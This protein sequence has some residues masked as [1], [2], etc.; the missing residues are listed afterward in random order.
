M[1]KN[2]SGVWGKIDYPKI[3]HFIPLHT[4]I[5]HQPP[6]HSKVIHKITYL[7]HQKTALYKRQERCYFRAKH[8][9]KNNHLRAK[10][11]SGY[12]F[13][14]LNKLKANCLIRYSLGLIVGNK[15]T[16]L[17]FL[18]LVKII[19]NLSIP[20]PTPAAGGIPYSIDSR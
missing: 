6:L 14:Y 10:T 16:S 12:F 8:S 11:L 13:S 7:P 17:I 9:H 18:V 19:T 2:R 4:I 15:I 5:P 20:I 1:A 3:F